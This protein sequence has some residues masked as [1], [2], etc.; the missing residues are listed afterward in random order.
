MGEKVSV[1]RD[2]VAFSC[3]SEE[4][5]IHNMLIL[6]KEETSSFSKARFSTSRQRYYTKKE[7]EPTMRYYLMSKRTE[8]FTGE[9]GYECYLSRPVENAVK[10]S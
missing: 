8:F 1:W 9:I 3:K 5:S 7:G 4:D 10:K 6:L 2:P